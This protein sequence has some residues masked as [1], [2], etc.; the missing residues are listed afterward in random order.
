MKKGVLLR[1]EALNKLSK[2][3]E[4][5]FVKKYHL[6]TVVDLRSNDEY[7]KD[8]DKIID[9]VKYIHLPIIQMEEMK[10]DDE[11]NSNLPNML[12][13]Y[14][15]MVGKNKKEFWTTLFDILLNHD[16]GSLLFHCTVGKDRTGMVAAIIL[17]ALGID[18]ET[19]YKD[20]LLT[21]E[22]PVI[23]IKY[24]IYSLKLKKAVRKQF[25]SLFLVSEEYLDFAFN[26][27][28][29]IYGS[30]DNFFKECCSLDEEKIKQ[31]KEK[32]LEA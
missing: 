31:L 8:I 32:Y 16:K 1:G 14:L 10:N 13:Y 22:H 12:L 28:D 24:K 23:D 11:Q 6:T 15:K 5:M 2:K 19:I 26:Q 25:L 29:E 20:Y 21:N 27:I 7:N 4:K 30:I 17:T 3:D 9:G 18:K